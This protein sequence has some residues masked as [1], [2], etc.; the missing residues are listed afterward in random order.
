LSAGFSKNAGASFNTFWL[1]DPNKTDEPVPQ[2][3]SRANQPGFVAFWP[4]GEDASGGF[5]FTRGL[6][7]TPILASWPPLAKL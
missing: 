3:E 4:V 2:R 7:G 6:A 5:E 1:A